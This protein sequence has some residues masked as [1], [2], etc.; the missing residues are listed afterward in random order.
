VAW[1]PLSPVLLT[2]ERGPGQP[3][4]KL[5]FV[6]S[7]SAERRAKGLELVAAAKAGDVK[8]V[9]AVLDGP[10]PPRV[11]HRPTN[12]HTALT[13]AVKH[14]HLPVVEA[15]LARGANPNMALPGSRLTPLMM[16]AREGRAGLVKVLLARGA[17][18]NDQDN[19]GGTALM[20]AASNNWPE[21]MI[22]LLA[23]GA[24]VD[25]QDSHGR[26]ALMLAITKRKPE[27]MKILLD[28]GADATIRDLEGRTAED[29][30]RSPTA[31]ALLQVRGGHGT[32]PVDGAHEAWTV[33]RLCVSSPAR[34]P[35]LP[36]PVLVPLARR[37]RA[38]QGW[39]P[40]RM[41]PLA[42]LRVPLCPP[43]PPPPRR[44]CRRLPLLPPRPR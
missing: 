16:A 26:T 21:V 2:G 22:V 7:A 25:D 17:R 12:H 18:V 29:L 13:V 40:N 36:L 27:V 41:M 30:A 5:G 20:L 14:D 15:L 42:L 32:R 33:I 23:K 4:P 44:R 6:L 8:E 3:E 35:R 39:G 38:P 28:R 24:R 9:L 10:K 19:R 43:P 11:D 34:L 1:Q 37:H 31:L